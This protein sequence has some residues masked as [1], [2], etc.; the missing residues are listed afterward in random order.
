MD[1]ERLRD[2]GGMIKYY[3]KVI[4]WM[5]RHRTETKCRQKR[6]RMEREIGG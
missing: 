5:W 4:R 1:I 2:L 3:L 6:R